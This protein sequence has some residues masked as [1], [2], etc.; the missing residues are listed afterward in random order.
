MKKIERDT[1]NL[2]STNFKEDALCKVLG[3]EKNGRLR[4]FGKGVTRTK[5]SFLSQL[6]GHIAQLHEE[7]VQFKS[8]VA[9]MQN[10]IDELKK[11]QDQNAATTEETPT[12]HIVSPSR[13]TTNLNSSTCKLLVWM[14]T[15]EVVAEG[16]WSS[17]DPNDSV[18]HIPLGPNAMR[19]WVDLVKKRE[20]YL[21]RPTSDM[22]Y[23]EDAEGTTVAWP[24]D[25]V[26]MDSMPG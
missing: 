9:H 5:L 14:G 1:P 13:V 25:K 20:V 15:G 24:A 11:N 26:L 16:R 6:N 10:A 12:P 22:L 3:P 18:H 21:W 2:S 4:T 17:S 23:I 19:V 8:Q 7:N